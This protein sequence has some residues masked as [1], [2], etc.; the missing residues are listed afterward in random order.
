MKPLL[1]KLQ[2]FPRKFSNLNPI[3]FSA[4]RRVD[5]SLS[6]YERNDTPLIVEDSGKS[7]AL[8][9]MFRNVYEDDFDENAAKSQTSN[10]MELTD[11]VME[12]NF[13]MFDLI[14]NQELLVKQ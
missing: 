9:I 5:F 3:L 6:L 12:H 1:R 4:V 11:E 13:I 8:P 2:S 10:E 7:Y 14:G